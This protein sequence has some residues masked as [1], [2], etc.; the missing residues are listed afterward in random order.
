MLKKTE[1]TKL[2]ALFGKDTDKIIEAIKAEDEVDITIPEIT[3]YSEDQLA[4]RDKEVVA[5]AKPAILKEGKDTGIE[6][7]LKQI[8]K[9]YNLTDVDTKDPDKVIAALDLTVTKGDAGLKEQVTLLQS[10]QTELEAQIETANKSHKTALFD[11]DLISNFPTNRKNGMSDKDYL[12]LVKNNLEFEETSDGMVVKKAGQILRDPKTQAAIA[13]KDAVKSL[14]DER[15]W[16]G[17]EQGGGRG[18]NDNPGGGGSGITKYSQAETQFLKDN[19]NGNP[20]SPE[21]TNYLN[22]LVKATDNFDMDN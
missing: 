20:I 12:L 9:K 22:T 21:F 13:P 2:K 4:T 11:T 8:A 18:G 7:G 6:I 16:L 14:F 17:E 3:T 15:K 1:L 19:P 10:K 5:A